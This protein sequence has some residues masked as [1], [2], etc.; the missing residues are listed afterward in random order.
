[1]L[2]VL[3]PLLFEYEPNEEVVEHRLDD[4]VRIL[5]GHSGLIPGGPSWERLYAEHIRPL[6]R[7]AKRPR[8]RSA[9]DSLRHRVTAMDLPPKRAGDRCSPRELDLLFPVDVTPSRARDEIETLLLRCVRAGEETVLITPLVESRNAIAHRH[10]G[11]VLVE[12]T[13]WKIRAELAGGGVHA[14][15]CIRCERNLQVGWT[16]RYDESLPAAQD[17]ADCPFCPVDDWQDPDVQVTRTRKSRP[18]FVDRFCNAWAEPSTG[19]GRH[20]DVY[21]ELEWMQKRFGLDQINVTKHGVPASEPAVGSVHHV[22]E[23]KSSRYLAG[24]WSCE[25]R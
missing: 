21:L 22:P 13:V 15:R 2:T 14:I 16:R 3:D 23:A 25:E 1:M 20:W 6:T 24:R 5:R 10:Q 9:L 4:A 18:A 12:K 17:A 11:S 19:G 8:V 7:Q